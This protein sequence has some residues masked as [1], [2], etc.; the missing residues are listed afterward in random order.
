MAVTAPPTLDDLGLQGC[1]ALGALLTA[2][3]R[4]LPVAPTRRLT[5]AY[6]LPLRE[7]G[8]IDAPWPDA[9]WELE[10]SAEETPIEQMQW[11]YIWSDYIRDGLFEAL[12]DFLE[13][14]PYDDFGLAS[15]VQLWR[16]LALAEAE[17][18]FELQL[19]KYNLDGSW[20]QDLTF[21]VRE[22]RIELPVAQWRY[23]C[24]A[25]T[26]FA[27][28][29]T[30]RYKGGGNAVRLREDMFA[31]LKRRAQRLSSGDWT[32]CSFMPFSPIPE[33]AAGRLLTSKLTRIGPLYW[34]CLPSPEAAAARSS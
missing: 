14:I 1:F 34:Q 19:L 25:A 10:P 21:A 32:G 31:E 3:H 24:W 2:Q 6:L 8:V 12:E 18:F 22:S 23:C 13:S 20:A 28:A 11:R 17:R 4:R 29:Q 16:D 9:R 7:V 33:S 15:R 26:R 27:A 5:L 30:Q